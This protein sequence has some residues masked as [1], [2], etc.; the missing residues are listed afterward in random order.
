MAVVAQ[1]QQCLYL[2]PVVAGSGSSAD[3]AEML[4][5]GTSSLGR[6]PLNVLV[7]SVFRPDQ[8]AA[9]SATAVRFTA[10]DIQFPASTRLVF[11]AEM[12]K[13][14]PRV[15]DVDIDSVWPLLEAYPQPA[16]PA[17]LSAPLFQTAATPAVAVLTDFLLRS[18]RTDS[19]EVPVLVDRAI[20]DLVGLGPGLTPAGDDFLAAVLLTLQ[21]MQRHRLAAS[22]ARCVLSAGETATNRISAAHLRA[23]ADGYCGDTLAAVFAALARADR[24]GLERAV[25]AQVETGHTSGRDAWY[26]VLLSFRCAVDQTGRGNLT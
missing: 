13:P 8:V 12:I 26:G 6:G 16:L 4:C 14:S 18:L 1:F 19:A 10:T 20:R 15:L 2:A 3:A 25:A 23:A 11:R 17:G 22:L 5:V 24:V 21:S 7:E 9:T